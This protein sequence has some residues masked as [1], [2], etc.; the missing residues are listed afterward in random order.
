[1][2]GGA[3][4]FDYR[5]ATFPIEMSSIMSDPS[6]KLPPTADPANP[7]EPDPSKPTPTMAGDLFNVLRGFCMGAAD[8]VPGVS[9][10]TVAL[11][12]GHY[13]RL[14]TAISHIDGETLSLVRSKR[15][16]AVAERLDT[17]F[18]VALAIG[19]LTGVATLAGLMHHLLEHHL[20]QT[21]AVFLGL[22]LASV[23]IVKSSVRNWTAGCYVALVGGT[24]LAFGITQLPVGSASLSLPYLFVAASVAI[25]AMILPGISG[26][27]VLLLFGVYKGITGVIK[28]AAR[29][30]VTLDAV[31]KLVTF[32]CGCAFGL[33]AFSK[34][35]RYL[36]A[37]HHDVTM[38]ALVGLML[39][40]MIKLYPLQRPVLPIADPGHPV[41]ELVAPWRWPSPVW[42]LVLM[43]L[44][45][46][47]VV[48][49]VERRFGQPA[50]A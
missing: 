21:L 26:A 23:W 7:F 28:D 50:T 8:T 20:P 37:N 1:M 47:A 25:C 34:L 44:V 24:L 48:L 32:G 4:I 27:F 5:G 36:L 35:L 14:I 6:G 18:M 41:M 12:L 9:G 15:F 31:A 38:S 29:G 3:I 17:R 49:G 42:P 19:I 16:A 39:G 45:A 30:N 13:Q 43:A 10:G 33:L 40:S 22:L 11:I 46:A 2:V